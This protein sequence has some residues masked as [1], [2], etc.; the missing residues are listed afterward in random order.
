M[1]LGPFTSYAPPSVWG[2]NYY[3]RIVRQPDMNFP[4]QPHLFA[5]M[6]RLSPGE[7]DGCIGIRSG[8]G[9]KKFPVHECRACGMQIWQGSAGSLDM[10]L[11]YCS[12]IPRTCADTL[13]YT[14]ME[15]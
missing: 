14:I 11:K 10:A 8:D 6:G 4:D 3:P 13:I 2:L 12:L 15:S 9:N 7:V 1:P 5:E